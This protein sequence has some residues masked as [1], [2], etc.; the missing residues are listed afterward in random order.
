MRVEGICFLRFGSDSS[1]EAGTGHRLNSC[2]A[3]IAAAVDVVHRD[4]DSDCL[5]R[6]G[7]VQTGAR[8]LSGAAI[9]V[10]Q[11]SV[12]ACRCR[13]SRPPGAPEPLDQFESAVGEN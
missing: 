13:Y 11:V 8:R 4:L 1:L 3:S 9:Y 6:A 2:C 12:H 7:S 5:L 10:L